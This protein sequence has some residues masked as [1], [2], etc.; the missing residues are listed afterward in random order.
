MQVENAFNAPNSLNSVAYLQRAQDTYISLRLSNYLEFLLKGNC[1][2]LPPRSRRQRWVSRVYDAMRKHKARHPTSAG[3]PADHGC[4]LFALPIAWLTAPAWHH[5]SVMQHIASPGK[6]Q[7]SKSQ[8]RLLP[9]VCR[10]CTI[11]N[12][13]NPKSNHLKLEMTVSEKKSYLHSFLL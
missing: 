2:P 7:K 8:G 6:S 11:V 1:L 4:W 5:E 3:N 10:V 13:E 9:N 12:L